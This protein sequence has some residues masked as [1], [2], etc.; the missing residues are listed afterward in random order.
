MSKRSIFTLK[1]VTVF[2]ASHC[3]KILFFHDLKNL[4]INR[5]NNISEIDRER[6]MKKSLE[7][8]SAKEISNI[9][10][11]NYKT[12]WL[13]ISKFNKIGIMKNKTR[14]EAKNGQSRQKI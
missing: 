8:I 10:N 9:L 6:M 1:G 3:I 4:M 12:V 7:G 14:D 13:I 11:L 2:F 5:R